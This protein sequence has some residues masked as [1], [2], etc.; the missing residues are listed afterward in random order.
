M[1]VEIS[2]KK[3][4]LLFFIFV[5]IILG[6]VE[7]GARVYESQK[8]SCNF[9]GK[10]AFN[11]VDEVLQNQ[12]CND[13][14]DIAYTEP[15]ILR[16]VPNQNYETININS[17]G[18]RGG[19]ISDNVV[20]FQEIIRGKGTAVDFVVLNAAAVLFVGNKVTSILEGVELARELISDGSVTSKLEEI[21][22]TTQSLK[23][24]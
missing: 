17:H 13:T 9:I 22:Q 16:F 8:L 1:S 7:I 11:Q 19:E 14:R 4:G 10:D 23:S 2:Y 21:I 18:F 6:V 12:V 3:Q 20:M 5:I 15:D 24:V